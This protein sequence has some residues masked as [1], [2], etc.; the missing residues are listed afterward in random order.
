MGIVSSIVKPV[1]V[2]GIPIAANYFL[3][4]HVNISAQTIDTIVEH[5]GTAL[6]GYV[7]AGIAYKNN[8][9]LKSIS[10]GMYGCFGLMH[11]YYD[12]FHGVNDLPSKISYV[13]D[14]TVEYLSMPFKW[15][16]SGVEWVTEKFN[17]KCSLGL[18]D[19]VKNNINFNPGNA[20]E[21]GLFSMLS[22]MKYGTNVI[23]S[24]VL[25]IL[26][27]PIVSHTLDTVGRVVNPFKKKGL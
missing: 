25:G 1:A 3:D 11:V 15:I 14:K 27:Y 10:Q 19:V 8:P 4:K 5:A 21:G 9:I 22:K 13:A 18:E 16:D 24:T 26:S 23:L 20:K 12:I 7:T 17:N 6:T 2:I